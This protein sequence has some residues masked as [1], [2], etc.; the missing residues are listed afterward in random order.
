MND[1]N[2]RIYMPLD[3][4]MKFTVLRDPP[5]LIVIIYMYL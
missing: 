3:R 4:V 2:T 5:L 1:K